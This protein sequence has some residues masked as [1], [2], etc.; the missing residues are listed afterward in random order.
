MVIEKL[1]IIVIYGLS[2]G[3]SVVLTETAIM[4]DQFFISYYHNYVYFIEEPWF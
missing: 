2:T 1:V 3:Q 4:T